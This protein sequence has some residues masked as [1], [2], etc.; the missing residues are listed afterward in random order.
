MI[1]TE[2]N[3]V[4]E[5]LVDWQEYYQSFLQEHGDP[6]QYRG[7][8]LFADGWMYSAFDPAGPEWPPPEDEAT[9]KGL[10]ITYWR[11][12]RGAVSVEV[13]MLQTRL[14]AADGLQRGKSLPLP[15]RYRMPGEIPAA[16]ARAV[17][18]HGNPLDRLDITAHHD[19]L[20][21][22]EQDVEDCDDHLKKLGV[23][24]ESRAT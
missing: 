3:P 12:R 19:R 23:R 16:T 11:L 15:L 1:P 18:N 7:R 9:L 22:L 24:D 20:A 2:T 14:R 4:P 17:D 10:Q 13:N 5:I 8:L 6:V 21:T